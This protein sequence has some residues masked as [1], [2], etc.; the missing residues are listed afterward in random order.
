MVSVS[1][2]IETLKWRI[3]GKKVDFFHQP[4]FVLDP[5]L[6][7]L[8][9]NHPHLRHIEIV[10]ISPIIYGIDPE[11]FVPKG[12]VTRGCFAKLGQS[13]WWSK[14]ITLIL[15][16]IS[17]GVVYDVESETNIQFAQA[18]NLL[19]SSGNIR[20]LSISGLSRAEERTLIMSCNDLKSLRVNKCFQ[21]SEMIPFLQKFQ[22][23]LEELNF[24]YNYYG[25]R[26][27]PLVSKLSHL[28]TFK[29][30]L[31]LSFYDAMYKTNENDCKD[32]LDED[33]E[34][35]EEFA[36][37]E[38]E[39]LPN[40]YWEFGGIKGYSLF[41]SFGDLGLNLTSLQ[42]SFLEEIND[43]ELYRNTVLPNVTE[44]KVF[45][46]NDSSCSEVVLDLANM[47]PNAKTYWFTHNHTL[48]I[49][50]K[51]FQQLFQ[52]TRK[53][54]D[55]RLTEMHYCMFDPRSAHFDIASLPQD[56]DPFYCENLP[57]GMKGLLSNIANYWPQLNFLVWSVDGWLVTH[58]FKQAKEILRQSENLQVIATL[59]TLFVKPGVSR[60][61]I[62][63]MAVDQEFANVT[64]V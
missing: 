57:P 45:V 59:N 3:I 2:E 50:E 5:L 25:K 63:S 39:L 13:S 62:L 38:D 49:R 28:K 6:E 10:T 31:S 42:L 48:E 20:R 1:I 64:I 15:T 47:C 36:Y 30:Q 53:F 22:S 56:T 7:S 29:Q 55:F 4:H 51:D 41:A 14:L 37:D 33:D 11:V 60:K 21:Q 27:H 40:D 58:M 44:L 16:L 9:N 24:G 17:D 19:S 46:M 26:S 34:E 43:G 18:L 35:E 52:T 8:V 61:Q 54:Q 12:L 32:D 23:T